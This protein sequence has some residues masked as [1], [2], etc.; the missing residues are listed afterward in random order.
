M[1]VDTFAELPGWQFETNE[2][3]AGVYEVLGVHRHGLHVSIKG[4][5]D[6]EFAMRRCK[7]DARR[8]SDAIRSL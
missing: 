3:S 7:E 8:L 6:P 4:A 5:T 1:T 2:I